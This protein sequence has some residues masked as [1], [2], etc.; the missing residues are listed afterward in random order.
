MGK[1]WLQIS[2][3]KIIHLPIV[4]D[5]VNTADDPI[6]LPPGLLI[7]RCYDSNI[8]VVHPTFGTITF[9]FAPSGR[10]GSCNQCGMCCGHPVADCEWGSLEN[11]GYILEPNLNWHVCQYLVIN[12]WR[13]WGD[14][15]NTEC[16]LGADIMNS[17][18]GCTLFPDVPAKIRPY[19][20]SC[21]Y[22]F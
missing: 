10:T 14:A 22:S 12:K 16:S 21:G 5:D 17:F 6:V 8:Q 2:D 20:T 9:E 4:E 1:I 13:K 19:M 18:K 3:G 11:C 7:N 15:G